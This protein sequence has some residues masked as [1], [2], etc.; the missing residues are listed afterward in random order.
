MRAWLGADLREGLE[1]ANAAVQETGR[2]RVQFAAQLAEARQRQHFF[3]INMHI[4]IFQ[5]GGQRFGIG[6]IESSVNVVNTKAQPVAQHARGTNVGG[7]HRFFDDAVSNASRL[8]HDI[9]H[10]TFFAQNKAI[11]RA[12]LE[13]QR[14]GFTPFAAVQADTVQQANL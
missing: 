5:Q 10:F 12:I 4:V 9:Q 7:N 8:G 1:P 3:R 6:R 2:L 13:D 11:I 14:V